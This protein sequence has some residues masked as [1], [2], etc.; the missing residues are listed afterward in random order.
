MN[1]VTSEDHIKDTKTPDF[2]IHSKSF[3]IDW[4]PNSDSSGKETTDSLTSH[5]GH[6]IP[7]CLL[8]SQQNNLP[9][10]SLLV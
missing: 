7:K 2:G 1:E 5:S 9:A 4:A 10:Q 3:P 8:K 6:N